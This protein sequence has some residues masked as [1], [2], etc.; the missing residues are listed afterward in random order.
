LAQRKNVPFVTK[1]SALLV[2][3]FSGRATVFR[4]PARL[5]RRSVAP[6]HAPADRAVLS[7]LN[8]KEFCR[9]F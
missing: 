6:T 7:R 5:R 3:F 2:N 9:Y 8:F 4:Q 1:Y